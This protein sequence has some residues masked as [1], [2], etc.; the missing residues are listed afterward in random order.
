M[1]RLVLL[2]ALP[3]N[4]FGL[5][6]GEWIELIIERI[7]IEKLKRFVSEASEIACF[8][9]HRATVELLSRILGVELKPSAKLYRYRPGDR[10][11]VVSLRTPIRG[12]EVEEVKLE[13]F[14]IYLVKPV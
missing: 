3:L 2:N 11:V 12:Q 7:S 8:V 9:R 10:I 6:E 5:E 14:E 4:M 13:D 1:Y